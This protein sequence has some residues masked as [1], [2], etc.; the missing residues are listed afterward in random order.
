MQNFDSVRRGIH[1]GYS[2]KENA[3][4]RIVTAD[5]LNAV[6]SVAHGFS[7][8]VGGVS[9]GPFASL[10]MSLT[11]DDSK[12][13]VYRN[14]HIFCEAFGEICGFGHDSLVLVNH[15]HGANVVRVDRSFRG[16]GLTREPLPFCDGM[17]TND[18]AVTLVTLH[19]DCSCIY[20]YDPEHN[21]IGLAHA[22]WKGTF[23]RVG[24]RMAEK[25]TAE[26]GSRPEKLIGAI[27]PCICFDCF[28]V[29]SSIGEDFAR[30]FDFDG[31]V[32]P[33]KPGKA[34][35]DLEAALAI[36]LLDAGL[37]PEQISAM[38]LC[39]YERD[40]LFFSYRRDRTET[41]AMIGFMKL[42]S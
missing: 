7:T 39:T 25:L 33:G 38:G 34:Y 5:N 26:Y 15:E 41:G 4:L 40:D 13:N 9:R 17:V 3:G 30:E 24:Q 29:D 37:L 22:G 10:N 20:L 23:K 6:S 12:L 1:R 19:A 2:I 35:V 14:Y 28:E 42:N 16:R 32:K 11:R 21:A 36:Q 31:I 8:R 27:G 18:S